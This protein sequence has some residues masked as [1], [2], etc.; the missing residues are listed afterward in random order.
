MATPPQYLHIRL[1]GPFCVVI[2][3]DDSYRIR[4][5]TI[6]DPDHKFV[7]NGKEISYNPGDS[8][9][10]QLQP[11]GLET[12]E[13]WPDI[14]PAFDWSNKATTNWNDDGSNCFI[15]MDLPYPQ[16]IMQDETARV[17]FDD[18]TSGLMPLNHVLVYEIENFEKV[19]ITSQEL[20]DQDVDDNGIF[21][22]ELGLPP[23]TPIGTIHDH[24]LMCYNTM[25]QQFFPDLYKDKKCCLKDIEVI[26][27]PSPVRHTETTTLEC[28]SGG[29][30]VGV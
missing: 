26:E 13:G 9:H 2:K 14:D 19:K 23:N 11:G 29:L 22:L 10:F 15:T 7:I 1:E 16:R 4:A 5:C 21:R 30:I 12:Y 3:K 27:P 17:I 24:S 28:K 8:F 25:L 18:Y 20:G 6:P